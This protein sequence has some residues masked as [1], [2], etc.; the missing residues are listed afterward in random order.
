MLEKGQKVTFNQQAILNGNRSIHHYPCD[1]Y[2]KKAQSYGD[3]VGTITRVFDDKHN[4]N[5]T[6]AD[7]QIFHVKSNFVKPI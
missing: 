5:L 4:G 6:M 1:S 2:L 7:G 3:Q